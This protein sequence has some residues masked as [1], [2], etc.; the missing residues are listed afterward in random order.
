[1]LTPL[2][3]YPI[4]QISE[5]VRHAGTSDRNFYDRYYF[6]GFS[7]D[8]EFM[9]VIGFGVY[10]NLG[11]ADAFLL[12]FHEGQH[13]VVRASQ[14]LDGVDRMNPQ[15]GP[16]RIEVLEGLKRLRVVVEDNETGLSFDA[17]W[18]GA[19]PAVQ[20]PRHYIREHGRII[21]DTC[22]LAQTGGWDGTVSIPGKSF[23]LT[24]ATCW[25]TRDR[26]WGTRPIGE[27]EP[28]GIRAK[29]PFSWFWIYT[30]IRFED[31]ALLVMIQER[32]DG[33]RVLEE[34]IRIWPDG[35][36]DWLGTPSH[37]LVYQPGT[38]TALGGTIGCSGGETAP[39]ELN[40]EI[41]I[42]TYIGLGT[43]YGYDTDWRHG[44]WQGPDP[45]VQGFE[46]DTT[47]PEGAAR[48]FGITDSGA[49]FTYTDE[50]GTHVGYGLFET[51]AIGPHQGYGFKDLLDGYE[52]VG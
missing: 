40:V 6:N 35:R 27:S 30:P 18:T 29:N 51:M 17:T 43:G 22:R 31:H 10:L 41:L 46:L 9:F 20:E 2:D 14:E 44:M 32:T 36:Q 7:H 5:P 8:G 34:A 25:G 50:R 1:M 48:L 39:I 37:A 11:V 16:I 21:F 28:P 12:V 23:T 38:R 33:S 42:R 13:R 19:A 15:V 4:H 49:R 52:P 3:D 26:S 47:S 45:V 24:D